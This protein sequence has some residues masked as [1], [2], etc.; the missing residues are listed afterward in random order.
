MRIS[1]K[2][3]G[4]LTQ[5]ASLGCAAAFFIS[6]VYLHST[7]KKPPIFITAQDSIK[8][9]NTTFLRV[10]SAGNERLLS[11]NIWILT[12]LESDLE[13]YKKKDLNN[14]LYLRFNQISELDPLFY[15]NYLY[16]GLYLSIVKDDPNAAGLIYDKGLVH[17]PDDY[18][19]LYNAGFN[20]YFEQ[21]DARRGI[22][23]L[24]R[25]LNHPR[26]PE[27]MKSLIAKLKLQIS[28]DY[29][30]AFA[31]VRENYENTKDEILR[32]KLYQ[33]LYSIKAEKD[34]ECLKERN[35]ECEKKDLDGSPYVLKDGAY[36]TVKPF[37]PF[38]AK[39]RKAK[40]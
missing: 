38:R 34:L 17:Y 15:E 32:A 11:G 9:L 33:D 4:Y 26:L 12:L 39:L 3:N 22:F 13:H 29:E 25:L 37:S 28:L 5:V 8:T 18:A 40:K 20:S 27:P 24:E 1:K 14:W 2:S 36:T 19:L 30:T 31:M 6:S 23:Y 21:A 10:I 16:G 35:A 7:M